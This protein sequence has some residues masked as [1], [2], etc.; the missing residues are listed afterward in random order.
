MAQ[1]LKNWADNYQES[2]GEMVWQKV[3]NRLNKKA[4]RGGLRIISLN[5]MKY[6]AIFL[7]FVAFFT[8][9]TNVLNPSEKTTATAANF[10]TE[11]LD[12]Q[13]ISIYCNPKYLSDLKRAYRKLNSQ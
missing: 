5:L 2:P 12:L 7:C 6:A 3:E 1:K 4:N 10:T 11:P 13:D 8:L 9:W